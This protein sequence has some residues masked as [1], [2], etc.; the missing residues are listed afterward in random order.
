MSFEKTLIWIGLGGA[1]GSA[2]R[3]I[4]QSQ[5]GSVSGITM[6]WGT[7]IANLIGSF[8]IGTVYAGFDRFPSFNDQWKLF[9]TAGICGGFTTFSAFSFETFQMLRTGNYILFI[10][11]IFFSIFGGIGSALTGFW[12]IKNI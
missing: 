12:L 1:I 9:L 2:L 7:L 5:F 3:Y 8:I 4:L 6:P 10:S 11:Y